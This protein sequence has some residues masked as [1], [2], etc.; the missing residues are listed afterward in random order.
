MGEMSEPLNKSDMIMYLRE[1]RDNIDSLMCDIEAGEHDDSGT[2]VLRL[3]FQW[4]MDDLCRAWHSQR[5]PEGAALQCSDEGI[6]AL[7]NA[8]PN[9]SLRYTLVDIDERLIGTDPPEHP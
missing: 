4:I 2:M 9:W 5:A 1:A 8:I 7:C 6:D 3:N